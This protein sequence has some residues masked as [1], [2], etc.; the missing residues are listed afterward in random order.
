MFVFRIN[1][2][3]G[4]LEHLHFR[5]GYYGMELLAE[6]KFHMGFLECASFRKI[7]PRKSQFLEAVA[8]CAAVCS[9]KEQEGYLGHLI[10]IESSYGY[11]V[12][13]KLFPEQIRAVE[14]PQVPGSQGNTAVT[15]STAPRE[16]Q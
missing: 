13:Q 8:F 11:E 15:V 10:L 3:G 16:Q 1:A 2:G 6:Y 9:V 4:K 5:E 12:L 14:L 7:L